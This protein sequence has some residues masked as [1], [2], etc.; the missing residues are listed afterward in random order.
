MKRLKASRTLQMMEIR[1][2]PAISALLLLLAVVALPHGTFAAP[3]SK[4]LDG[5]G[6]GS[7]TCTEFG[8]QFPATI[9]FQATEQAAGGGRRPS[10]GGVIGGSIFGE[11][12]DGHIADAQQYYL[13]GVIMENNLCFSSSTFTLGGVCGSGV[14]IYL[15]M[16]D[17]SILRGAGTLTGSV[18]CV[19]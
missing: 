19:K 3:N 4:S 2:V 9:L 5:S 16:Y 8:N 14:T 11:I 7:I 6:T 12:F 15:A 1:K 17:G 10:V 13:I 18:N